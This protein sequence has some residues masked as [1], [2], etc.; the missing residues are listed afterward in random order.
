MVPD[1]PFTLAPFKDWIREMWGLG[2]KISAVVKYP[3]GRVFQAGDQ[4]WAIRTI[5]EQKSMK[6]R[7]S[8]EWIPSTDKFD[9][10]PV[11]LS[12]KQKDLKYVRKYAAT[13]LNLFLGKDGKYG[14][15]ENLM[16]EMPV[17][18]SKLTISSSTWAKNWNSDTVALCDIIAWSDFKI[19]SFGNK[20]KP[21]LFLF[22]ISWRNLCIAILE[23]GY[24]ILGLNPENNYI[25]VNPCVSGKEQLSVGGSV[26]V[27]QH[28]AHG[29][30]DELY[31]QGEQQG[32]QQ[33]VQQGEQHGEQQGEQQGE[34]HGE[35]QGD[36]QGDQQGEQQ[37]EEVV[38]STSMEV[39]REERP[40][41]CQTLQPFLKQFFENGIKSSLPLQ[42][43]Q[44]IKSEKSIA[45]RLSDSDCWI[46]ATLSEHFCPYIKEGK[47]ICL[48]VI[49]DIVFCGS[50]TEDNLC[51][52]SFCRPK[53]LQLKIRKVL[54]DPIPFQQ[55]P[56]IT[57]RRGF[58][59]TGT[60][61]P[62]VDSLFD[63]RYFHLLFIICFYFI[64]AVLIMVVQVSPR[65]CA[66]EESVIMR[67]EMT[68]FLSALG[69]FMLV[70][71]WIT[72]MKTTIFLTL[73]C[74]V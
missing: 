55:S 31:V 70:L 20:P 46:D 26:Q 38:Q 39:L 17:K 5:T 51:I 4:E 61:A 2:M 53:S 23:V 27:E 68:G 63:V 69:I 52:E 7:K 30:Q 29:M 18:L 74:L 41:K 1:N 66:L 71:M 73:E 32:E 58:K 25:P 13:T 10:M 65:E 47:V 24:L 57:T 72:S 67:Q 14:E 48:D 59:R 8:K 62:R 34:H 19:K 60:R 40:N 11:A 16:W 21:E 56:Q 36:Q 22:D 54:G 15:G 3:D 50:V 12:Q 35:Q 6:R 49:K 37:G 28:M 44:V 9:H 64:I 43:I 42:I 33:G 45:L